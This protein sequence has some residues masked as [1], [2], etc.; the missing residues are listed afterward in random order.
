[1]VCVKKVCCSD[2]INNINILLTSF[3]LPEKGMYFSV[4]DAYKKKLGM[5]R[6]VREIRFNF[7]WAL[8]KQLVGFEDSAFV[9]Y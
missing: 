4:Q 9:S 1:L 3:I 7:S 8:W 2:E 5:F 6:S